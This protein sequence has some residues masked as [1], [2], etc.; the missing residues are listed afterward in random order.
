MV[1]RGSAPGHTLILTH[2][3]IGHAVARTE[4]GC[5]HCSKN[6]AGAANRPAF[7]LRQ[8]RTDVVIAFGKP[9]GLMAPARSMRRSPSV[10]ATTRLD[11]IFEGFS[12]NYS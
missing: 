2:A 9:P 1:V 12:P 8:P 6:R 5:G 4:R 10:V 3:D 11:S 7:Q